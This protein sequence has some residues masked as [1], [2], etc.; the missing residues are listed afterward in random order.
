MTGPPLLLIVAATGRELC[1]REGLVC[2]IGPVEAAAVTARAIASRAPAAVVH[3]GIA[4]GRGLEPLS[5]VVGTEAIYGD[6][7][8][9]IPLVSRIAP[10]DDLLAA[11]RAALPGSHALPIITSAVVGGDRGTPAVEAMEGF[12]VLRACALAGVP[13][14]EIRVVS[15]EIG[16]RDRSRWQVAEA[17]HVLS[18]VLETLATSSG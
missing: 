2:G 5:V 9:A 12:G 13:A 7:A 3:V 6:L 17:L 1:G 8:A 14:V 18:G 10:D 11:V 15:N 4:G 16:E